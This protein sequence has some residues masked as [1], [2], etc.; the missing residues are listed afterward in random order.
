MARAGDTSGSTNA[1]R[2]PKSAS[3]TNTTSSSSDGG[4]SN[5]SSGSRNE[6]SGNRISSSGA[7][8]S[9]YLCL[10]RRFSPYK[11]SC[12][13]GTD[14]TTDRA[15]VDGVDRTNTVEEEDTSTSTHDAHDVHDVHFEVELV[16]RDLT[17]G[18]TVGPT[19]GAHKDTAG[20]GQDRDR[21]L[22]VRPIATLCNALPCRLAYVCRISP[23]GL[24]GSSNTGV[25]TGEVET[26]VSTEEVETGVLEAGQRRALTRIAYSKGADI[27]F[28][29]SDSYTWSTHYRVPLERRAYV[30]VDARTAVHL[31]AV[32][33]SE[34]DL[35]V[36]MGY[37]YADSD[38]PEMRIFSKYVVISYIKSFKYSCSLSYFE[39]IVS[40]LICFSLL[41]IV[42]SLW[43]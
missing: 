4:D 9:H 36:C 39:F 3:T 23:S 15:R 27:R 10:P 22:L 11:T 40:L 24:L 5:S 17:G 32:A 7:I 8:S 20:S 14:R 33:S 25:S 29:I 34:S 31:P 43:T 18:P 12:V 6:S 16:Y 2:G 21:V 19:V 41:Y 38:V 26:G 42:Y 37:G 30:D 13:A 1:S 35:T 28:C